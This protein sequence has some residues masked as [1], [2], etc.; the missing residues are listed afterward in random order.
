VTGAATLDLPFRALFVPRTGAVAWSADLDGDGTDE[1]ILESRH[2]RAVFSAF[3]GGRWMDFTWKDADI[4]CLPEQ[5]VFVAPGPVEVRAV[6]DA[7]EFT[8]KGWKRTAR[9][10]DSALTVE[11]TTALPPDPLKDEKRGNVSLTV[12][13]DSPTRVVYSLK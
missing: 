13:R 1:W 6:G 5:G 7:L 10:T 9:L 12:S 4:D 8:G 2:A 3:D 11:Q